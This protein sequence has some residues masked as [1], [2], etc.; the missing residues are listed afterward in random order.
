MRYIKPELEI[1]RFDRLDVVSAS[2]LGDAM[3]KNTY[4][5]TVSYSELKQQESGNAVPGF[6]E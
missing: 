6:S 2:G 3:G 4:S 5:E 1:T